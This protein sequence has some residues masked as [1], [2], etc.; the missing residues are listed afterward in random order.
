M[1]GYTTDKYKKRKCE[2]FLE[3]LGRYS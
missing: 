3:K 1:L 2:R